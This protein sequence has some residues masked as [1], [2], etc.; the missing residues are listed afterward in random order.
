MEITEVI[1]GNKKRVEITTL[2][3]DDI[4]RL[5]KSRYFFDWSK[6]DKDVLIFKLSEIDSEE[7]LGAIAISKF[8]DEFRYEIKLL[9]V[10]RENVGSKKI[11][12]GIAGCLV[13]YVCKECLIESGE[14]ACVS[15]VPKTRLKPH[16]ITKYGMEDAG[17]QIFLA[18]SALL[19]LINDY[20]L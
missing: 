2:R 19:K 17:W 6:V 15:L 3:K 14:L 8:P 16:Y 9:A 1:T 10:S 11:Y 4:K 18:D 12:E 7:I 5:T 20:N 13:A